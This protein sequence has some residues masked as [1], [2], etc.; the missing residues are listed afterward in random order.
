MKSKTLMSWSLRK[1]KEG[2][3]CTVYFVRREFFK[4]FFSFMPMPSV[5]NT[6]SEYKY[7]NESK[8]LLHAL[9]LLVFKIVESLQCIF[10]NI[11]GRLQAKAATGG[12][13]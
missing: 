6:L 2:I 12:I 7:F 3:F 5:L 4:D 13:L 9:L 8:K 10:R 11:F 1:K